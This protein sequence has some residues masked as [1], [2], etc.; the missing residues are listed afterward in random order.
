M[1][2]QDK[3]CDL[4]SSLWYNLKVLVSEVKKKMK[5]QIELDLIKDITK[6]IYDETL[7]FD[8]VTEFKGEQDVVTTTDLFV[9]SELIK[10]IKTVFPDDNFHTEEYYHETKLKNRTWIIDPIDG[11]SNYASGLGLFVV[12][13]A[14][15][16]QED[17]VLSFIYLPVFKKTFYAIKGEGAYLNDQRYFVNDNLKPTNFMISMVG[18]THKNEEKIYYRRITDFSIKNKYKLRMLGSI[19]LEL[20]LTSEGVFDLFYTNVTN[21]WDLYP[22]VLLLKEA[23]AVLINEKGE[24]YRLNDLNLF[25]CKN[26]VVKEMIKKNILIGENN[27]IN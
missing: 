26:Q 19:G 10:S 3:F 9:E 13:I 25:A 24:D 18:I 27:G 23:G 5:Y 17:I 16:D 20:A 4:V 8:F 12:Q 22:G 1:N 2:L 7:E 6:R 15:Y 11:T 21:I 14:L